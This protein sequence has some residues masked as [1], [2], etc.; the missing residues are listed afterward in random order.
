VTSDAD[1]SALSWKLGVEVELLAPRGSDRSALAC[2]LAERIGGR[3]TRSFHIDSEPSKV[4]GQDIFYNLTPAFTVLHRDGRPVARLVDDQTLQADLD[5]AAPPR[6]GWYRVVSDDRRLVR[7]IARHADPSATLDE[8]LV[9]VGRLFGTSPT[10]APGGMSKLA[11]EAD[12]SV[13]I[14]CP[15]PG[16]R[17]R[18][19]EIVTPPLE[20]DHAAHLA[21]LL[22]TAAAIGFTAPAEGAVH[23][24]FDASPLRRPA[25]LARLVRYFAPRLAELRAILG[26]NPRCVRLGAWP[27]ALLDIVSAPDFAALDWPA[28]RERLR[29]LGLTKFCDLNLRNLVH[30]DPR[31]DTFEVRILPVSL[32]PGPILRAAARFEVILRDCL[33]DRPPPELSAIWDVG[34]S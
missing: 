12:E 22:D 18:P 17:E 19:C 7:L 33:A 8:V 25:A 6:P 14:A 21:L 31:K 24:H 9:P 16:E 5:R 3:V 10:A 20:R 30:E 29:P 32:E 26:T 27:S 23:L 15:L 1:A 2:V 13:A 28:A 34:A 11:D 4:P